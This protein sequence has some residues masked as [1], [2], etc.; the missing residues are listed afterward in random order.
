MTVWSPGF[1][2]EQPATMGE[3]LR[4]PETEEFKS[5]GMHTET[6]AKPLEG[7]NVFHSIV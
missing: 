7:S 4:N 5:M 2:K 1:L 6:M 3:M